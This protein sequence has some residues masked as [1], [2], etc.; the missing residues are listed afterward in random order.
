MWLDRADNHKYRPGHTERKT[1]GRRMRPSLAEMRSAKALLPAHA[2]I[3][4]AKRLFPGA[5][6]RH[7]DDRFFLAFK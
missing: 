3:F 6:D 4:P 2:D 7:Q 5:D 1:A